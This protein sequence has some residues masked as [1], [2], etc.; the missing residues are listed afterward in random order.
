M[1]VFEVISIF[2]HFFNLADGD[3]GEKWFVDQLLTS[4]L[5]KSILESEKP[6]MVERSR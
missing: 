1:S 6:F 4:P 3:V 2:M 5:A